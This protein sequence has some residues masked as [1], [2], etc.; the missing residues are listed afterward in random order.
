MGTAGLS[1]T[2]SLTV[3]GRVKVDSSCIIF[4]DKWYVYDWPALPVSH[5]CS[6]G[7]CRSYGVK[8]L[9]PVLVPF[10][11]NTFLVCENP[12]K[13][14]SESDTLLEIELA[15]SEPVGW[16]STDPVYLA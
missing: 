3:F 14:V 6:A 12:E 16:Q 13:G 4:S 2:Y 7:S 10:R 8:P 9:L 5:W 1:G 11:T 15:H